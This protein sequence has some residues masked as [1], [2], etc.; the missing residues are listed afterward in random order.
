MRRA[1]SR[2]LLLTLGLLEVLCLLT[3]VLVA[4][5][6]RTAGYASEVAGVAEEQLRREGFAD[7]R[8]DTDTAQRPCRLNALVRPTEA[9]SVSGNDGRKERLEVAVLELDDDAE[10]VARALAVGLRECRTARS[11]AYLLRY[12]E[13]RQTGDAVTWRVDAE[14]PVRSSGVARF[15][16]VGPCAV[17]LVDQRAGARAV[18]RERLDR[19]EEAVRDALRGRGRGDC[20]G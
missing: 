12:S 6:L 5:A 7:V 17:Y 18:G 14:G 8:R 4:L 20:T 2:R 15:R 13:V 16:R 1:A 11:G 10:D 19:L 9:V 3:G